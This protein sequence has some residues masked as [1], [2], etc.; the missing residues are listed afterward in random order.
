MLN[1]IVCLGSGLA[2]L[3][4]LDSFHLWLTLPMKNRTAQICL[5]IIATALL[6]KVYVIVAPSV[7][8]KLF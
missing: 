7:T 8:G 2:S 3:R 4:F 6:A 1:I 5:I